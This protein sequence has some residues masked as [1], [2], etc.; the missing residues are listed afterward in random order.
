MDFSNQCYK[1][2]DW[3]YKGLLKR[4]DSKGIKREICS[5]CDL[6]I[7]MGKVKELKQKK[8]EESQKEDH[9]NPNW[10]QN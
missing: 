9:K 5:G 4:K 2:K 8:K 3:F 6:E 10:M 7:T 1:C